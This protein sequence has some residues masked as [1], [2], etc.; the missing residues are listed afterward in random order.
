MGEGVRKGRGRWGRSREEG[1]GRS[2]RRGGRG[3]REGG[4]GMEGRNMGEAG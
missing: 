2:R 3:G 4:G 1:G